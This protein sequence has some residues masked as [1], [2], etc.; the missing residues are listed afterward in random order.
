M[1]D[2]GSYIE[3]PIAEVSA[4]NIGKWTWAGRLE[5]VH[6][7]GFDISLDYIKKDA[8]GNNRCSSFTYQNGDLVRLYHSD[9]SDVI[10]DGVGEENLG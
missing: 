8:V 4:G 5:G 9:P 6:A 2:Y 10:P 1:A 3:L 7:T